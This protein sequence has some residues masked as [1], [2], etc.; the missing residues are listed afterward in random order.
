MET[1]VKV[2]KNSVIYR[3][4]DANDLLQLADICRSSFSFDRLR[5]ALESEYEIWIVAER[6]GHIIAVVS[7]VIEFEYRLC[8]ILFMYAKPGLEE[9]GKVQNELLQ[10]LIGHAARKADIIY[11]TTHS[12]NF[13]QLE[14]TTEAG[15]KVLGFFPLSF[16]V[17]ESEA[18]SI[19]AYFLNDTLDKLRYVEFKLHPIIEPFYKILANECALPD[20]PVSSSPLLPF[21]KEPLPDLEMIYAPKFVAKK[22][23]RLRERKLLSNNFYP[24]QEP[25]AIICDP[26]ELVEVFIGIYPENTYASII[27]EKLEL[28]VNPQELYKKV[29]LMLHEKNISYIE[30]LVDAADIVSIEYMAQAG[31]LPCAYFPCLKRH[32]DTR[33]DFV[34]LGK[35]FEK[36]QVAGKPLQKIYLDYINCYLDIQMKTE[37]KKFWQNT[38]HVNLV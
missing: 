35:T 22:H 7:A 16:G 10:L 6:D 29:L 15:F 27:E 25:N 30:V 9:A 23:H 26:D 17:E 14:L 31:F 1:G 36:L 2:I 4:A 3:G 13:K 19:T 20:L 28:P 24:F 21:S 38:H 37:H 8:K 18:N 33:R 11:C 34:I 32:G 5:S 12:V